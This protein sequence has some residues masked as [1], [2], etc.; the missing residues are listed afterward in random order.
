[1]EAIEFDLSEVADLPPLEIPPAGTYQLKLTLEQK[2]IND[3]AKLLFQY[4][5]TSAL[6]LQ[7]PEGD[8]PVVGTKFSEFFNL[9]KEGLSFAKD[10]LL[11]LSAAFG[12]T[13]VAALIDAV[14][15]LAVTA[16]VSKK[17]SK[18]DGETYVNAVVKKLAIA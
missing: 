11:V 18:K 9:N 13:S 7:H 2:E 5:V 6:S 12:T 16:E 10:K 3:K 8:Q 17:T 15:D 4:E 14:K 1:M